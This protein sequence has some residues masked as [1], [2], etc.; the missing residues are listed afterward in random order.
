MRNGACGKKAIVPSLKCPMPLGLW[1]R[2]S[3]DDSDCLGTVEFFIKLSTIL[4]MPIALNRPRFKPRTRIST[5]KRPGGQAI[6]Q[7]LMHLEDSITLDDLRG[8]AGSIANGFRVEVCAIPGP[9]MRG[10]ARPHLW[11]GNIPG[12]GPP[13]WVY[14]TIQQIA[15]EGQHGYDRRRIG[16]REAGFIRRVS[17]RH[18]EAIGVPFVV[19]ADGACCAKRKLRECLEQ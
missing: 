15:E 9:R 11:Y 12:S 6:P 14:G 1:R 5:H 8:L 7:L 3:A 13:A 4:A 16:S 10:T 17:Q 19:T 2:V 18:F